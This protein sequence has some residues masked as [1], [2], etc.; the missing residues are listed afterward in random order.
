MNPTVTQAQAAF[1]KAAD[2]LAHRTGNALTLAN[3]RNLEF[4]RGAQPSVGR[5]EVADQVERAAP[6]IL[7]ALNELKASRDA[8]AVAQGPNAIPDAPTGDGRDARLARELVGLKIGVVDMLDRLERHGAATMTDPLFG[9]YSM[10][11]VVRD[12][13]D[14]EALEAAERAGSRR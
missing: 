11:A 13:V 4:A 2:T 14:R 8:L 12:R 6:A 1:I 5:L 9:L 7:D 3:V 10:L